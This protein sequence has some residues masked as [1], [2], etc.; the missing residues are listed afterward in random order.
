MCSIWSCIVC[1]SLS[2]YF[3]FHR[4]LFILVSFIYILPSLKLVLDCFSFDVLYHFHASSSLNSSS[5]SG[6]RV[7]PVLVLR[8]RAFLNF[9]TSLSWLKFKCAFIDHSFA[10]RTLSKPTPLGFIAKISIA[11][12]SEVISR[13]PQPSRQG[14]ER[15]FVRWGLIQD[16]TCYCHCRQRGSA[17]S[18]VASKQSLSCT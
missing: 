12:H 10:K 4:E 18:P 17:P 11:M 5:R 14:L 9:C 6:S 13:V 1:E 7:S 2:F 15:G 3:Q 8:A 16:T